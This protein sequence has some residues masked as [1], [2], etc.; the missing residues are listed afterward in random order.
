[1]PVKAQPPTAF[2][3]N[4]AYFGG[5]VGYARG[6][7]NNTLSDPAPVSSSD[8][9][10]AIYGGVHVG[11]NHVIPSGWLIGIEADFSFPN[12]LGADDVVWSRTTAAGDVT[13][14]IDYIGTVRARFG[15]TFGRTLV[16]G[17]GG[18]AF[19]HGRFTQTPG[20]NDETD[21]NVRY[22]FGWSAGAGAEVAIAPQWTARFEYLYARFGETSAPFPSGTRYQSSF[23]WHTARVGLTRKLGA[24]GGVDPGSDAFGTYVAPNWEMHSQFTYI[25]Q[26]YGRFRSPYAGENSFTPWPQTRNTATTGIY[27]G[28]RLWEGGELYYNPELLQGFGL[29]DTSGAAG[30]PNGEAQKSNFP[31]PH[32]NTSR[33]FVRQTF[34]LGG[35]QEAIESGPNQLSNKVDVSRVTVQVGKFAVADVFDGNTYARDT[36][37]DFMNWSVWSAG[38]FD[39]SADKVG[40]SYGA[41]VDFNQ[42]NWALRTGYFLM[43]VQSNANHFDMQVFKRG[44]YVAELEMRYALFGRPGKLRTIGWVNSSLSGSYR[45]TLDNP[46]FNL[47]IAQTR[48]DRI[49]YGYVINLEQSV[50][51]DI[52]LFGRW[53]WNDGKTEIISFTDIDASLSG[54]VSIKGNAWGRP[55][56]TWAVGGAINALSK[57]HRDFIAAG[58]MG[59]LIGD[60]QLNYRTEQVLETYYAYAI[61]KSHIVTFDYQLMANP[62]YNADR[63]PISFFSLRYH[64]EW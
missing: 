20:V 17:T 33:L 3:W 61:N 16:Y 44:S 50:T 38:A 49:K 35:E 54:G 52:G 57:D 12:Y 36:R 32:Y 14:Q 60:G 15:R 2:D 22:R 1:M 45:E 29:H 30:Y 56:D 27:L 42:K 5:H 41:V 8:T 7:V 34:G 47:D 19:T 4:G 58:G 9:F 28:I 43:P 63:G 11:Y 62:A 40:L 59:I 31:Y 46:V 53:S 26:G 23:D 13:E 37:K 21:K 39:Y 64:A 48:K 10:G 25:Q 51:D 18:W 6:R 55:D 24:P